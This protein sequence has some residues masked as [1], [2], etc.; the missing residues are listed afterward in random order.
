MDSEFEDFVDHEEEHPIQTPKYRRG[1]YGG[2]GSTQ[3][4]YEDEGE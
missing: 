1:T 3:D 2:F 4:D